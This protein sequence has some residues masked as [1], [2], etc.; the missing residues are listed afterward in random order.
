MLF[1]ISQCSETVQTTIEPFGAP[2]GEEKKNTNGISFAFFF[3]DSLEKKLS[4]MEM[5]VVVVN[6]E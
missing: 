6:K 2:G 3:V 1:S 4:L 5:M